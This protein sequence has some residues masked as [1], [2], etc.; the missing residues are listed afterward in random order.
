MS[1]R[2]H[3]ELEKVLEKSIGEPFERK[4]R[5]REEWYER[6]VIDNVKKYKRRII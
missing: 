2:R 5:R 1:M 3:D 6:L 4:E